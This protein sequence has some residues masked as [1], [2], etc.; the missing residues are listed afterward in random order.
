MDTVSEIP[1]GV[2]P[3]CNCFLA[4]L[5]SALQD[6]YSTLRHAGHVYKLNDIAISVKLWRSD[7][8]VGGSVAT[9][10][11]ALEQSDPTIYELLSEHFEQNLAILDDIIK[12]LRST[13]E[14]GEAQG[15]HGDTNWPVDLD[16]AVH[17]L[18]KGSKSIIELVDSVIE[19]RKAQSASA[20]GDA[21]EVCT[22]Q[23]NLQL[24]IALPGRR[25]AS[26]VPLPAGQLNTPVG[27]P[28]RPSIEG[29]AQ[30]T[31]AD[32]QFNRNDF[33]G[34]WDHYNA[35]LRPGHPAR[36]YV[37]YR[38][39]L[40]AFYAQEP[41]KAE[42]VLVDSISSQ[43]ASDTEIYV[44]VA[45]MS[46]RL[47]QVY[48]QLGKLGEAVRYGSDAIRLRRGGINLRPLHESHVLM[49]RILSLIGDLSRAQS[50]LDLITGESVDRWKE[51]RMQS[52]RLLT[53]GMRPW[54][55]TPAIETWLLSRDDLLSYQLSGGGKDSHL[56][57]SL[58][59]RT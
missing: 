50:F 38:C 49:W 53:T 14:S 39:A 31:L 21:A 44:R 51:E 56:Q 16:D 23:Q 27:S 29:D 55:V 19:S 5:D 3:R 22:E 54:C 11:P 33:S 32:D 57:P 17:D 48:L 12:V 26:P 1:E 20:T 35:L 36:A 2:L 46:H 18:Q 34:A 4:R 59:S 10:S 8:C 6:Y 43:V 28:F 25:V 30:L 37:T 15:A 13:E 41:S 58:S 24:E 40:S 47:A 42:S 45:D 52:Y 7:V 9:P